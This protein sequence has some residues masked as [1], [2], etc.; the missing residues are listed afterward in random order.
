[1]NPSST[2]YTSAVELA[3]HD[4]L[5]ALRSEESCR[6]SVVPIYRKE[7]HVARNPIAGLLGQAMS[8]TTSLI[9]G[10]L[11]GGLGV[12]SYLR[13]D[14]LAMTGE[15]NQH[16]PADYR[17]GG[18]VSGGIGGLATGGSTWPA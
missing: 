6:T 18:L 11:L 1:M 10:L 9:A 12:Y 4:L 5:V 14:S 7:V 13:A 15:S 17:N 2:T 8:P 16:T 3:G